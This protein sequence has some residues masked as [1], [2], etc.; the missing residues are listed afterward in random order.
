MRV[1]AFAFA[2]LLLVA[3]GSAPDGGG[4]EAPSL[5]GDGTPP[6]TGTSTT[7]Q[8]NGNTPPP[9]SAD[10]GVV[11]GDA[12]GG[13]NTDAASDAADGGHD[14]GPP[15]GCPVLA[16]PSGAKIQTV[17][18]AATTASYANHLASG[19]TAPECFL[20]TT[21]LVN[22]DTGQ[23]YDLTVPVATHFQLTELV[24]TEVSQG[25]G[26]HVLMTPSAVEALE[27]FREAVGVAVSVNSGFRSPLHQEAVCKG[28]CGNPLGCPGTCANNSRHMW[29]DAFDLP[30][31]FYTAHDE[32]L[33][34]TAGF[35]YAYLESGTH[36][37]VDQNPAY[38]TCVKQ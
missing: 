23:V 31:E 3:C 2:S 37:H 12:G 8:G 4:G 15:N 19:Q 24:G 32:D 13:G 18:D 25:Y 27:K 26:H 30:L 34:C 5:P 38:P 10:G 9:D 22:P 36:L 21:N 35:K 20:D 1:L 14:A 7:D 6:P 11:H 16:F 29:G 33:A 28:L 17:K